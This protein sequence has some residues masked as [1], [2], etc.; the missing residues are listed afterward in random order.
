MD[1]DDITTDEDLGDEADGTVAVKNVLPKEWAG[2]AKKARQAALDDVLRMLGRRVPPI[3]EGDLAK[4]EELKTAVVYGALERIF[5]GAI[6]E[7]GDIFDVLCKKYEKKYG[8][9]LLGL[10]PTVSGDSRANPYSIA[11]HRR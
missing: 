5:R 7:A 1:A 9:E 10:A 8:A 4:P 6:S 3:L 2:S 11:M